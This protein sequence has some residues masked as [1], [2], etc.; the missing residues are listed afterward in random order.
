M[1]LRIDLHFAAERAQDVL[2]REEQLR[3]AE[4]RR[5]EATAGLLPVERFMQT[6]FLH[7]TAI[8]EI[9]ERF[10]SLHRPRT[11][12]SR[13][14]RFMMTRRVD[15]IFKVGPD[16]INVS[17]RHRDFVLGSLEQVLKLYYSAVLYGVSPAPELV[18]QLSSVQ[19]DL[20][21]MA[22]DLQ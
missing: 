1:R 17:R 5:I 15:V 11:I 4:E 13:L 21:A 14:K 22:G 16:S 19:D 20:D 9:V 2:T 12:G 7:S 10:V 6:F 3:I 8:A 18:E